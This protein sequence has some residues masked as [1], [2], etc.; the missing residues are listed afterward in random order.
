M[1]GRKILIGNRRFLEE[2]GVDEE[3]LLPRGEALAEA[4]KTPMFV[5]VDGG[6][7]GLVAVADVVRDESREAVARLHAL[8]LDVAMLTGD[9][10]RTAAAIAGS[11]A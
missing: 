4:G 2:S 8:G 5:V 9:N 11:S 1:E 10:R 3:G 6:P 7:A